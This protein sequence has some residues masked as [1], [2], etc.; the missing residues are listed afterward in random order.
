MSDLAAMNATGRLVD[1][2]VPLAGYLMNVIALAGSRSERLIFEAALHHCNQLLP[3]PDARVPATSIAPG[4]AAVLS[5]QIARRSDP[6]AAA[7]FDVFLSYNSRDV[8]SVEIIA[9]RLRALGKRPWF[10]PWELVPGEPWQNAIIDALQL[11]P[12]TA[13]LL[14]P[15]GRGP[16]HEKEMQFAL[17]RQ[18]RDAA[19]VIPVLLP[20]APS[21]DGF[22][23]ANTWVDFRV[24][25]HDTLAAQRLLAGI[26]GRAPETFIPID[27]LT[28]WAP[29]YQPSSP[30]INLETSTDASLMQTLP[31]PDIAGENIIL[32][33]DFDRLM[34][35]QS[36]EPIRQRLPSLIAMLAAASDDSDRLVISGRRYSHDVSDIIYRL[37]RFRVP[38]A[39]F[40]GLIH[41][42]L[43]LKKLKLVEGS[44]T[45]K[46]TVWARLAPQYPEHTRRAALLDLAARARFAPVQR[47]ALAELLSA[48]DPRAPAVYAEALEACVLRNHNVNYWEYYLELINQLSSQN[49]DKIIDNMAGPSFPAAPV[50]VL[51]LWRWNTPASDDELISLHSRLAALPPSKR[52]ELVTE[53]DRVLREVEW[54]WSGAGPLPAPS[55]H[56][57]PAHQR[58]LQE[59]DRLINEFRSRFDMANL[60]D[61]VRFRTLHLPYYRFRKQPEPGGGITKMLQFVFSFGEKGAL[62]SLEQLRDQLLLL[63]NGPMRPDA[64]ID[65]AVRA[66]LQERSKSTDFSELDES[67]PDPMGLLAAVKSV[68]II[69]DMKRGEVATDFWGAYNELRREGS[70]AEAALVEILRRLDEFILLEREVESDS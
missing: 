62:N 28:P 34:K 42:R 44:S 55:D 14:G 26:E 8:I 48:E 16:W 32:E 43:V 49:L 5:S 36:P 67:K 56:A 52:D 68:V 23:A 29:R 58:I 27:T 30:S 57:A 45:Q 66:A 41:R 24:G 10:A 65:E 33:K 22:L 12:V 47:M 21:P 54:K 63:G 37:L 4:L 11:T 15:A 19:R 25:L 61:P 40:V 9:R 60:L 1:G 3:P 31:I 6:S 51:A 59:R 7:P 38:I 39:Q 20:G 53:S 70:P 2:T 17:D 13:V 18:S 50:A 69:A 35:A 64:E 46:R